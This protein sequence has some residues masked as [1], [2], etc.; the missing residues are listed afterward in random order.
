MDDELIYAENPMLFAVENHLTTNRFYLARQREKTH[1]IKQEY[2][3]GGLS[4]D[5]FYVFPIEMKAEMTGIDLD[6]IYEGSYI[7]VGLYGQ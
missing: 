3:K 2:E 6:I 5:T 4:A 7:C 1:S